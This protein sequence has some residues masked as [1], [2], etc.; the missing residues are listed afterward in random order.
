MRT[1]ICAMLLIGLVAGCT[2]PSTRLAVENL[3]RAN[4]VDD[5]VF[6]QQ[7][8]ALRVLLYR[9]LAARLDTAD[10]SLPED[11]RTG[12]N[13]VWNERDLIEFWALQHER[14]RAL[15]LV[16]VEMKLLA[17]QGPLPLLWR[18]QSA[19]ELG[20]LLAEEAGTE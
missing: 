1:K 12:L 18:A 4:A 7:H 17:D 20:Q 10:A 5:G 16:G 9:D 6:E 2:A 3:R 19:S 15:R 13:E 14:A 8:D 11:W